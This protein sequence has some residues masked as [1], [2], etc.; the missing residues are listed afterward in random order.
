MVSVLA[1]GLV[2]PWRWNGW[3]LPT[4]L[5][6]CPSELC[7]STET[8]LALL[9]L[10][11][12]CLSAV[13]CPL[14]PLW[15]HWSLDRLV[16]LLYGR[17]RTPPSGCWSEPEVCCLG[18]THHYT[19]KLHDR[20]RH[21]WRQLLIFLSRL[22]FHCRRSQLVHQQSPQDIGQDAMLVNPRLPLRPDLSS[23]ETPCLS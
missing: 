7:V 13:Q 10:S 23:A 16:L 18:C 20:P 21:L 2:I 19:A 9:E 14:I 8:L 1:A 4:Q 11:T 3:T 17:L 12:S 15:S 5:N 6:P 22:V